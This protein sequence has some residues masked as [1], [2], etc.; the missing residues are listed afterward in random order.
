MFANQFEKCIAKIAI[1]QSGSKLFPDIHTCMH[2]HTYMYTYTYMYIH[3]YIHIHICIHTQRST[4]TCLLT[5]RKIALNKRDLI[6]AVRYS[7]DTEKQTFYRMIN[8]Y[9]Y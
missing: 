7:P 3:V 8:N 2:T 1:Q 6:L 9:E 4:H 5:C